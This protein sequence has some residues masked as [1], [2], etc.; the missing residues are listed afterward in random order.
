MGRKINTNQ[1]VFVISFSEC[2]SLFYTLEGRAAGGTINGEKQHNQSEIGLSV[3]ASLY[4]TISIGGVSGTLMSSSK[5]LHP[6]SHVTGSWE[7]CCCRSLN[8]EQETDQ[9]SSFRLLETRL[10]TRLDGKTFES[11]STLLTFTWKQLVFLT[12]TVLQR[13]KKQFICQCF[14]HFFSKNT[15][16]WFCS[17]NTRISVF[18]HFHYFTEKM[19]YRLNE[20]C[21]KLVLLSIWNCSD[22][23]DQ[24]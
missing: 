8:R 7:C 16:F 19:I 3:C 24:Q 6:S 15:F 23:L 14:I 13:A 21:L 4:E 2:I 9:R 20:K 10:Q 12:F 22:R 11:R 5:R 17:S 1:S 18:Q